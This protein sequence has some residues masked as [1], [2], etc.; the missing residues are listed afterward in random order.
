MSDAQTDST[1][2]VLT[3][4]KYDQNLDKGNFYFHVYA[5]Q[6]EGKGAKLNFPVFCNMHRR[7]VG[8]KHHNPS[9]L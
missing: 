9:V 6:D 8:D 7:R 2:C 5:L 3:C 4:D 1:D